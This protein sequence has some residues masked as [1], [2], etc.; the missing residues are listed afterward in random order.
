MLSYQSSQRQFL[1]YRHELSINER[2]SRRFF[3]AL[4]K[5]TKQTATHLT[6]L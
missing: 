4:E 3:Q 2:N 5:K 6:G 1:K